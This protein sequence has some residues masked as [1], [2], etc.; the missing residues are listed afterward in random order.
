[1]PLSP[2]NPGET[3]SSV[4]AAIRDPAN[5][6]AWERFFDQYAPFL[7]ALAL[8]RGLRREDAEDV[9]Q[10]VLVEVAGKIRA[11][12]YDRTR[13]RFHDWL[14]EAARFR[15]N[16]L[17]R[18]NARREGRELPLPEAGTDPAAPGDAFADAAEAEWL[19]LLR[20]RALERLRGRVSR[21]QFELFHAAAIAEWPVAR[22]M[23]TYGASRDAV[24]QAK[25]RVTPLYRDILR[26]IRTELDSPPA[27][28][29]PSPPGET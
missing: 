6:T 4:L 27:I 8:R 21:R 25:H 3:R 5:A 13:G 17:F 18:Q 22:V 15:I 28:P 20:Q 2:Y 1:M 14:A 9:V 12:D 7:H 19:S 23:R 26:E 24:Y 29:P 16:D 11:F 10:T